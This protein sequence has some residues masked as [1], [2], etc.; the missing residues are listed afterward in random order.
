[1]VDE[2]GKLFTASAARRRACV[3]EQGPRSFVVRVEGAYAANDGTTY[4]RYVARLTFRADS[5][6]VDLALTH[7]N[8]YLKTEFTDITS[9]CRSR[10][11]ESIRQ[12]RCSCVTAGNYRRARAERSRSSRRTKRS[13]SCGPMASRAKARRLGVIRVSTDRGALTV[14]VRD[15]WQRW[16]KGLSCEARALH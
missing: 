10:R 15:F 7:L 4:M 2:H 6:R 3:E 16:P 11:P 9:R 8:D 13:A 14:A 1:M 5:P 12:E